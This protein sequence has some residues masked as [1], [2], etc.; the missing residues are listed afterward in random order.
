MRKLTSY[1]TH[2]LIKGV[3]PTAKT[4]YEREQHEHELD[5]IEEIESHE[6][7]LSMQSSLRFLSGL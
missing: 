7:E 5:L 2:V 3:I 4:V 1:E 6:G